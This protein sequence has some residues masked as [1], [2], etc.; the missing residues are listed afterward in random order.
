MHSYKPAR[1]F[2][3]ARQRSFS[4]KISNMPELAVIDWSLVGQSAPKLLQSTSPTLPPAD[5]I[6]ITWADAE[7]AAMQHVFCT[8]HGSMPYSDRN[9]GSWSGWTKYDKGLPSH[10]P[11][12]WIFW[13]EWRLVEIGTATVMLFKSNTHLDFPG[14]AQLTELIQLLVKEAQPKLILS[15]GTAGGAETSDHVGTVRAV[16][17]GTLYEQGQPSKDWPV[18][19]NSWT[20]RDAVLNHAGFQK[21]LFPVPTT[22]GNLQSLCTQ[23]NQHY[24][25]AYK[26]ADLDPNRLNFGDASPKISDDTR[27][28]TSLLTTP[29]FVVGTTSG[30]YQAYACIEMDDAIIGQVCQATGT[31]FGFIRNISDPVQ[32][33]ALPAEVQGNWGSAIYDTYGL[34]TS[35]NGAITAWAML[36]AMYSR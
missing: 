6:V 3:S 28:A 1:L 9:T 7:W 2:T 25:T 18:Y 15:I 33:A 36:A 4:P 29:T 16:R 22:A 34:Y 32:S 23:F 14:K 26:L 30:L 35:Y 21:L 19:S 10:P 20:A 11:S 24:S 12:G 17:S 31:A 8:P 5:A 13:G 27:S